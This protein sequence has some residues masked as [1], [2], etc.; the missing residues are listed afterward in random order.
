MKIQRMIYASN[1][2]A[3]YIQFWPL[4]ARLCLLVLG[5]KPTLFFVAPLDTPVD[6]V[7]GSEIIYVPPDR[8]PGLPTCYIAQTI[9]LLAPTWFPNEVCCISD[10]DLMIIKKSFLVRHLS[11]VTKGDTLVSLNRYPPNIGR[12]SLC[13]HI[14]TG[15]TFSELFRVNSGPKDFTADIFPVLK[16]WHQS[17]KGQWATD[18]LILHEAVKQFKGRS[19]SRYRHIYTPNMWQCPMYCVSHYQGFQWSPSKVNQYVEMEPPFPYAR[20]KDRIHAFLRA[21]VPGFTVPVLRMTQ[22]GVVSSNRHPNKNSKGVGTPA[23]SR[24][25]VISRMTSV[26][27]GIKSATAT[28]P[29]HLARKKRISRLV[30]AKATRIKR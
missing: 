25:P 21:T 27:R 30:H 7:P 8:F 13:Y 12:A 28:R 18:E 29:L 17:K 3:N 4:V 11:T 6:A 24:P 1:L 19:P 20:H 2:N 10:I 26:L 23:P 5:A 22:N 9:R 15:A 14:A 16:Q